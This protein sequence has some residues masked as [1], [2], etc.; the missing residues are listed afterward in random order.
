MIQTLHVLFLKTNLMMSHPN[1]PVIYFC[2]YIPLVLMLNDHFSNYYVL[3]RAYTRK[4]TFSHSDWFFFAR[5]FLASPPTVSIYFFLWAGKKGEKCIT[6]QCT[7]LRNQ[8]TTATSLPPYHLTLTPLKGKIHSV[9]RRSA[10]PH[11]SGGIFILRCAKYFLR[12]ITLLFLSCCC[13]TP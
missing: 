1:I 11:S 7:P 6:N 13:D 9:L 4:L 3:T 8:S 2:L 12:A 10:S 5:L